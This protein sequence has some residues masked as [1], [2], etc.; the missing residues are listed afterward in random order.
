MRFCTRQLEFDY[1][2]RVLGHTNSKG[3]PGKC[4]SLHGHRGKVQITCECE[5]LNQIGVVIDF[6]LVKEIVGGWIDKN[7]D[8]TMILNSEDPVLD[9][10]VGVI[11][12]SGE[13]AG[14]TPAFGPNTPY[15]LE[16]MNPTAE[17]L[18]QELFKVATRL[19]LPHGIR[20]S[21]V[22]FWET[23]NCYSTYSE[24]APKPTS[25]LDDVF[26]PLLGKPGTQAEEGSSGQDDP[27][28]HIVGP[29][30]NVPIPSN[31]PR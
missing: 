15:I 8:H 22:V 19:L 25:V 12:G 18:A 7:W 20:V 24:P 27:A 2:H 6:G 10:Y 29:A 16:K 14:G 31:I 11:T 9:L 5:S 1:G 28:S 17:N 23:P 26:A 21:E 30:V 4:S 3:E 13:A